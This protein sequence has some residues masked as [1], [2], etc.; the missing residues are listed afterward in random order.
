VSEEFDGMKASGSYIIL[1]PRDENR[2]DT[3]FF[4]ELSKLPYLYHIAFT[5]SYGVHI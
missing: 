5:S 3:E 1:V 2:I 4:A